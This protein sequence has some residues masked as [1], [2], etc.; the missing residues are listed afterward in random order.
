VRRKKKDQ[1]KE[2][3]RTKRNEKDEK[4][5]FVTSK[6]HI[7]NHVKKKREVGELSQKTGFQPKVIIQ[8]LLPSRS[9]RKKKKGG[10]DESEQNE[11]FKK[12]VIKEREKVTLLKS[13]MLA[14]DSGC[15]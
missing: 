15:P 4:V 3:K 2:R 6:L 10:V 1:E 8:I 11:Y 14:V 12:R 13:F 7:G 5:F 9:P